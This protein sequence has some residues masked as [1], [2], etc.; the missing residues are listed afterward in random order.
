MRY[1]EH[2]TGSEGFEQQTRLGVGLQR[3]RHDRSIVIGRIED[4]QERKPAARIRGPFNTR[5]VS[6]KQRQL[7]AFR[8]A[9]VARKNQLDAALKPLL[10]LGYVFDRENS[11]KRTPRVAGDQCARTDA[12]YGRPIPP[13]RLLAVAAG[14]PR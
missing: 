2:V 14:S 11:L 3:L 8:E 4:L 13:D 6:V 9:I 1:G 5:I 10:D 7:R 12:A